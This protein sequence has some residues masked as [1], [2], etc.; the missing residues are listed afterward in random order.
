MGFLTLED[1]QAHESAC[2]R[3]DKIMSETDDSSWASKLVLELLDDVRSSY[4]DGGVPVG[5]IVL[6]P[7]RSDWERQIVDLYDC[8]RAYKAVM[9]P[10]LDAATEHDPA[11]EVTVFAMNSQGA[12]GEFPKPSGLVITVTVKPVTFVLEDVTR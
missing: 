5:Q 12:Y 3:L 10:L 11:A 4:R 6:D 2:D 9:D 8:G 7:R 1:H